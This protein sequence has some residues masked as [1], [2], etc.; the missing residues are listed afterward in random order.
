MK[1]PRFPG[2]RLLFSTAL[3]VLL[4]SAGAAAPNSNVKPPHPGTN[5]GSRLM[6]AGTWVPAD[7]HTLDFA[8]L[9]RLPVEH[10]VVSDVSSK[11]GV[12]QHNYLVHHDGRFWAMWSEGPRVEDMAG[13]VVKYST[14]IDGLRWDAPK[15]LTGYPPRSGPDSP[16]YNTRKPEG[17]R[18]ISR[19]LWVRDGQLLALVSLDEAA[20]F[21]G[22]SLELRAYRWDPAKGAWA[23]AGVVQKDAINNFAPQRLP[24]GEWAMTRRKHDYKTTGVELLIGGVEAL[25]RWTSVPVV[26]GAGA[27][28]S[29]KAEEPIWYTLPDRNLVALFRDNNRSQY[30]FRSFST[31]SGRT[32]STPVQTDFPDAR[33]KLFALRMSDGRYALVSNSNPKKRDPMTLAI[34]RDGLVYDRLYYIVGG[35]HVDYPHM[36]EHGGHLYIAHSGAKMSVE[37][38]RVRIADIDRTPMPLVPLVAAAAP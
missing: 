3:G 5:P 6:L 35:R 4:S 2:A 27:D 15:P 9:P 25:D 30:L 37:I 29:L 10:V 13:Q 26:R 32:W 18:Y 7:P 8:K 21:F 36:M 28:L 23:D 34:S 38:E 19:G 11:K 24:S 33:S 14:S 16:Y 12:N 1:S 20:E 22:P 17:L 31:D